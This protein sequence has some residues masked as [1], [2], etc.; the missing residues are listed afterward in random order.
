MEVA[1]R[2]KAR[3]TRQGNGVVDETVRRTGQVLLP[4][5]EREVRTRYKDLIPA[6]EQHFNF[7]ILDC[8]PVQFLMYQRGDFFRTHRDRNS[9]PSESY[10]SRNRGVSAVVF[11]N[12]SYG[13]VGYGGGELLFHLPPQGEEKLPSRV[14][15]VGELGM[16]VAF[17]S[18]LPHEVTRVRWGERFSVAGWYLKGGDERQ[19]AD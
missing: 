11:L 18:D 10:P 3:V 9:D 1:T 15:V 4:D 6:L 5:R 19:Q 12:D 16:L 2:V 17:G 13:D 14:R 8:E 7:P